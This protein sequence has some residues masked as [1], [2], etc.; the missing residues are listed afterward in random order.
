MIINTELEL[1]AGMVIFVCPLHG[2]SAGRMKVLD[3]I[4]EKYPTKVTK[5]KVHNAY[6]LYVCLDPSIAHLWSFNDNCVVLNSKEISHINKFK[7]YFKY[8]LIDDENRTRAT[9]KYP[10]LLIKKG[11]ISPEQQELLHNL[12]INGKSTTPSMLAIALKDTTVIDILKL[13]NINISEH[14]FAL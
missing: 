2:M 7:D 9:K 1:K 12:T 10:V 11:V 6:K 8:V 4:T 14:I 5:Y 13:A 3:K